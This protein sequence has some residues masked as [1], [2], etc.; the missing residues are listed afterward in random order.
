MRMISVLAAL[1]GFL[2]VAF[3]AFAAHGLA[4]PA[5][6][7]LAE[8]GARYQMYHALA[9]LGVVALMRAGARAAR[10]SAPF[11]FAG[12]LLFSGSLY[13]LAFGAPRAIGLVT[14]MGGVL[15]LIGWLVLGIAAWRWRADG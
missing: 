15:L 2:A 8:T 9:G 6:K 13:A 1:C 11:F 3:G 4:D 7:S 12:T 10:F 14:P 5:A